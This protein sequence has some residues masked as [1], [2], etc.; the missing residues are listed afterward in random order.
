MPDLLGGRGSKGP[1]H[2]TMGEG[3]D[4]LPDF[5]ITGPEVLAPLGNAVGLVH[6]KEGN[7]CMQGEIQEIRGQEPLRGHIDDFIH[8]LPGVVQGLLILPGR[9]GTVEIRA[10]DA[11]LHQSVDL[12]PHEGD[13][14]GDYQ[15]NSREQDAGNLEADG[16]PRAG[17]HDPQGVPALE[18]AFRQGC[19]PR[20]EGVVSKHLLQGLFHSLFSRLFHVLP[21]PF[22]FWFFYHSTGRPEMQFPAESRPRQFAAESLRGRFA[23]L[24]W[25]EQQPDSTRQRA[26]AGNSRLR[27]GGNSSL[28]SR[29][30]NDIDRHLLLFLWENGTIKDRE[31]PDVY[32]TREG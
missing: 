2:R 14:R 17:G 3:F 25:W 9:Q 26:S 4:K 23:F 8:P 31:K 20:T 28:V 1:H 32:K 15:G 12:V 19:L 24:A 27:L 6:T 13:E 16:F 5:Q 21:I 29:G 10:P 7:L 11:G 30:D 18:Q 22:L